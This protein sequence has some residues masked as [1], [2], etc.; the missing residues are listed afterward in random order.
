MGD[1]LEG[2]GRL[3]PLAKS[4]WLFVLQARSDVC[5]TGKSDGA[6]IEGPFVRLRSGRAQVTFLT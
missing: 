3:E 4:W 6:A 2:G 5:C 1:S